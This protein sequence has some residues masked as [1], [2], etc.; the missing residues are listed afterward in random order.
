MLQRMEGTVPIERA[1]HAL[2]GVS[3]FLD[4]PLTF[5]SRRRIVIKKSHIALHGPP[6]FLGKPGGPL[7]GE[8]KAEKVQTLH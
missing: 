6:V 1:A 2:G 3:F 7:L 8:P 5:L 4:N